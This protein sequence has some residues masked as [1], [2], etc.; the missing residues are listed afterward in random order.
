MRQL[1]PMM[2]RI[3]HLLTIL[4]L[5]TDAAEAVVTDRPVLKA[6]TDLNITVIPGEG[7]MTAMVAADIGGKE[8]TLAACR[9]FGAGHFLRHEKRRPIDYQN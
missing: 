2:V 9:V 4:S 5:C 7:G 6:I 3:I 8:N 1:L